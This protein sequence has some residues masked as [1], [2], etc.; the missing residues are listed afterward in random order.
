MNPHD[1]MPC[2]DAMIMVI[3]NINDMGTN[4][5]DRQYL[6]VI[7]VAWAWMLCLIYPPEVR[8][9]RVDISCRARVHIL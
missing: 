3:D 4:N 9:L 2:N 7:P 8:G 5:G 6:I 1:H